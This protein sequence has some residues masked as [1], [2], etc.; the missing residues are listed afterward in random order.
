M[1]ICVCVAVSGKVLIIPGCPLNQHELGDFLLTFTVR[2]LCR[3]KARPFCT[4]EVHS[5]YFGV[6]REVCLGKRSTDAQIARM[7]EAKKKSRGIIA[8]QGRMKSTGLFA[9]SVGGGGS[10]VLR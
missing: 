6:K 8:G 10:V 9:K 1:E 3:R 7:C 5:E 4:A 2:G